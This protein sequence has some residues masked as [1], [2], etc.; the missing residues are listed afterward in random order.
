V[1]EIQAQEV[2]PEISQTSDWMKTPTLRIVRQLRGAPLSFDRW[3][4]SNGITVRT[5]GQRESGKSNVLELLCLM[6]LRR[7]SAVLDLASSRDSEAMAV[8]LGPFP[9]KVRLIVADSCIMTSV[10]MQ[11]NTVPISEFSL[12]EDGYWYVLP[13][14]GFPNEASYLRA[15]KRIIDNLWSCDEWDKPRWLM[16]R[17]AQIFLSS[18]SRTTGSRA[19]RESSDALQQ[20]NTEARHHGVSLAIDSQREVEVSRSLRQV[21]DVLILKRLGSWI[22]FPDD[23]SFVLNDV[24][25]AAFRFCPIDKAFVATSMG[26]LAFVDVGLVPF[27]HRRGKSILNILDVKVSFDEQMVQS[28]TESS[29]R[30]NDARTVVGSETHREIVR[31]RDVERNSF[32]NISLRLGVSSSTVKLHYR[33]HAFNKSKG[34]PCP[35]CE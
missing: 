20:L 8:L 15:M 33:R 31:L 25:P 4:N 12:P 16:F 32:D 30:G 10:K 2:S 34:I 17:E 26:Q 35:N 28:E 22:D 27:H 11:L 1:N 19:Q 14:S 3:F 29:A 9:E 6:A 24:E 5:I 7:G 23:I 18:I 13:R 21:S